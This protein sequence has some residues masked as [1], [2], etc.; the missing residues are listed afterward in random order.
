MAGAPHNKVFAGPDGTDGTPTFRDL[1]AADLPGGGGGSNVEVNGGSALGT[2]NFND[3]TPA[4]ASGLNITWQESS[5][6]VSAYTPPFVASGASHAP[7]LVPDPGATAG[8]TKFLREDATFAVPPGGGS[9]TDVSVNGGSTLGSADLNDTTPAAVSG[10]NINWQESGGSVSAYVQDSSTSVEGVVKLARDLGGTALLPNV[11]GLQGVDVDSTAPTDGQVLTYDGTATKWKPAT[12]GSGGYTPAWQ[13]L[14]FGTTIA[15]DAS[16]G[17]AQVTLTANGATV[18]N[19]TSLQAGMVFSIALIQDGTG[20]WGVSWGTNYRFMS[21]L[22]PQVDQTASAITVATFITDGTYMYEIS[23]TPSQIAAVTAPPSTN[24]ICQLSAKDITGLV[25]GDPVATWA[26]SSG[27]GNNFTQSNASYRPKYYTNQINGK[28]AVKFASPNEMVGP[29]GVAGLTTMTIF[30]VYNSTDTTGNHRAIQ[31]S[32]NWLIGPYAT[33]YRYYNG[34]FII[35]DLIESGKY[36][37]CCI[38]QYNTTSGGVFYLNGA[39]VGNNTNTTVPNNI[40]I[41]GANGGGGGS[42]NE[43][44]NGGIAEVLIYNAILSSAERIQA[45]TYVRNTYAIF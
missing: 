20:G 33:E 34:A 41:G 31:G 28:S 7:G 25:D 30:I 36:V 23:S 17:S 18:G 13:T 35:G 16:L 24:L 2:A 40:F 45:E 10:I 21:G 19:P 1:V 6:D 12:G 38:T 14:T 11:V 3:S 4:A 42:A 5:G 9:G 32:N 22:T 27:L 26:D 29:A 15:W 37:L 43:P 44:L 8:T 39:K